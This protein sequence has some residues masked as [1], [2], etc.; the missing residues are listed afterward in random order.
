[1]IDD[2]ASQIARIYEDYAAALN[3]VETARWYVMENYSVEKMVA[4]YRKQYEKAL[5]K[6][7]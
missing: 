5:S 1:M 6:R 2:C 7:K 4:S 3:R